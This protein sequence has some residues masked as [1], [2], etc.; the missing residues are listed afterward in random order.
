[1]GEQFNSDTGYEA[2]KC[3]IYQVGLTGGTTGWIQIGKDINGITGDKLGYAVSLSRDGSVVAIGSPYNSANGTY[4]GK[5]N[6]Y[7]VGL[8]GGT[9]GWIKTG[10]FNGIT[11]DY[12]GCSVSLSSDGTT[13]AVGALGNN[14]NTGKCSVYNFET[15]GWTQVGN[16]I[17]GLT[18]GDQSGYSV[19]LSS[20]G[21]SVAIGA[22]K[23]GTSNSGISIIYQLGLTGGTTGWI[24]I[25]QP[26]GGNNNDESGFSLSLS[27]D[28]TIVAIGSPQINATSTYGTCRIYQL[29]LTGITE[30]YKNT[31]LDGSLILSDFITPPTSSLPT[32]NQ[33]GYK[34]LAIS[35]DGPILLGNI[36]YKNISTSSYFRIPPGTWIV[37]L[38]GYSGDHYGYI[39]IG[40]TTTAN[41]VDNDHTVSTNNMYAGSGMGGYMKMTSVIQQ[42]SYT[43]WYI[44]GYG[45]N[46]NLYPNTLVNIYNLHVYCTR[47]A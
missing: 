21:N 12:F 20:D 1:M 40:I 46:T 42:L 22:P 27:G 17:N 23:Y 44:V 25:G 2:G 5:I 13:V 9:T 3:S 33:I 14:N 36:G 10:T 31:I 24:Q 15:S 6:M 37:E 18:T 26:I 38:S 29:G 34:Y 4:S 45:C 7:Q 39:S 30:S 35:I 16:D 19:S 41:T 32:I 43:T 8:T 11:G 47:I 28:G